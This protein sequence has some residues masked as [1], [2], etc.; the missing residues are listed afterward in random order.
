[1]FE[2]K[3]RGNMKYEFKDGFLWGAAASGPQ[4][5]GNTNKS[6][7]NVWDMW[8]EK[9]P[10]RFYN[11][12]SSS[13][14]CDTYNRYK[15][16]VRLMKDI[17]LN[18]FR[19]SIQWA[20]LID[21]LEVGT[22]SADAVEFYNMYINEMIEN[23]IEPIMNLYHFDMPAQLMDK[24]GGFESKHVVTLFVKYAKTCFELFGDRV[25]YFTIFN[26]PIV[27]VEGGYFYDFHYPNKI[28]PRL[29]IQVAYNSILAQAK[30]VCEYRKLDLKGEVGT[31]LNLTPAYPRSDNPLDLKASEICD[32]IF[33]KSFVEPSINGTFPKLLIMIL[34]DNELLPNYTEDELECIKNNTVDFVGLNY[35]VPRRVCT[36]AKAPNMDGPWMP[37]WYFDHYEMPGS[38]NNPHRDNNEIYPKAVYDIAKNIQNNYHNIKWYLAEIGISITNEE[39]LRDK[40]G[41]IDDSFRTELFKEHMI[42][43]HKAIEEGSNCFGVHQ[44]TFI[45]NWSWIN[46]H[47]RRYGFYYL[48]LETREREIKKH[49]LWFKDMIEKNGF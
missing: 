27:P 21:D 45:D 4:T 5:E 14:A 29:G 12:L 36:P 9:N 37:E 31:T 24:Y 32:T 39:N 44:W 48:D 11:Q 35:Y 26:E 10:E 25:K 8:F 28:A 13:V 41:I 6:N 43:L 16:D 47:K 19:T 40:D 15:D 20:R 23:G 38:R 7:S 46:S 30:A 1:M 33:N 18:S 17:N 42:Q 2:N 3:Q 49:A 22:V 34:E